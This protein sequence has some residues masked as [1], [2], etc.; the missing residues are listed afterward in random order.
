MVNSKVIGGIVIGIIIVI[1]AAYALNQ[2]QSSISNETPSEIV[3]D[4]SVAI[5]DSA[6]LNQN[7]QDFEINE[8]GTKRYT[9]SV[10]DNPSLED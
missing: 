6:A 8:D 4:S 1:V 9:I 3:Q 5:S 7:N 10:G 2:D